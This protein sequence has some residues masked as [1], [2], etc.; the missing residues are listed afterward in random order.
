MADSQSDAD[1]VSNIRPHEATAEADDIQIRNK[2][3]A[4][5]GSQAPAIP[6]TDQ[7][8]S[9]EATMSSSSRESAEPLQNGAST[10]KE[11]TR[12][13]INILKAHSPVDASENPFAQLSPKPAS[14]GSPGM[15]ITSTNGR[16][17]TPMKRDRP[18]SSSGR[19]SSR[20]PESA[21]ES[22]DKVL[23]GIFRLS[24]DARSRQDS[25]GHP[26]HYIGGVR[27]ELEQQGGSIKLKTANI[28]QALLEAA[29]NLERESPLDY[30]LGC[31]KRVAKQLR[32]LKPEDTRYEIVK[33]ARRLCMSYCIFA[34][35]MPDMFG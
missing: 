35:S 32:G 24:L 6:S 23:R 3:L 29:S 20:S 34:V 25:H 22:E 27:E 19:P 18:G 28:D 1:K 13:K 17:V 21:E 12:P 26:L 14:N 2:R 33:E 4:K 15:N 31:W 8:G 9:S 10:E 16:G 11:Q 30:L 5:L 7:G